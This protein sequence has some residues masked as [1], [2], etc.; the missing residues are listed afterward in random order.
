MKDFIKAINAK[1]TQ[2]QLINVTFRNNYTTVYTKEILPLL[3]T[4]RSVELIIDNLTGCIIYDA[5]TGYID[6]DFIN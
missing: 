3:I 6:S 1:T 4:D 2:D 5:T